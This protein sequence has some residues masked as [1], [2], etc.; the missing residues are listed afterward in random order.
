MLW[1][2]LLSDRLLTI[3]PLSLLKN[4]IAIALF[5]VIHALLVPHSHR[6]LLHWAEK[7]STT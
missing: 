3:K 4:P 6:C 5:E 1:P 7:A 2:P